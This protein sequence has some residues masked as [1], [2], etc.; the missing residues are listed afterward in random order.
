VSQRTLIFLG[1]DSLGFNLLAEG[2]GIPDFPDA[3]GD[4]FAAIFLLPGAASLEGVT[5]FFGISSSVDARRGV[6]SW[7]L[8]VLERDLD[9]FAASEEL[10]SSSVDSA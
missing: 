9:R 1:V 6:L 7:L 4:A 3:T 2:D 5:G 10:L 8:P